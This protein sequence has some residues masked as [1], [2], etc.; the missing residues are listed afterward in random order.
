MRYLALAVDYDG[1]AASEDHLSDAATR[2]LER[3]PASGRRA[4]LLTGRRLVELFALCPQ[5]RLFDLV[6]AEN[7]AV[8]YDPRRREETLLATPPP[9]RFIQQLRARG[10]EPLEVGKVVVVAHERHRIII[11]E[12]IRELGLELQVI[13]NRSSVM[14]LP[15]GV[16]K[17]SG[18]AV[19]LRRLGLSRH[20]A[21]GIGDAENDYSFIRYCECGAA[22]ANAVDSLKE[23]ADLVTQSPN[24]RGVAELVDE[25]IKNDL[26]R[27]EGK[28]DRH[29]VMIGTREDG[30]A[31]RIP[32]YGHNILIA[33]PSGCGKS[34]GTA[35][36]VERLIDKTYQV[37]IIDP[38][39]DYSALRPVIALGNHRRA[40]SANEVLSILEDP[41]LN[42][43]VN[44]LGLPLEDRPFFFAQLIP[45]LQAMRARN[46]RPHWII[47]DEAH[48]MLPQFWGHAESTMPRMLGETILVTVHPD[49]VSPAMLAAVDIVF[50]IGPSPEDTL[51]KFANAAGRQLSWPEGLAYRPRHAVAWFVSHGIPP[52]LMRPEPTRTE[53][54]RHH[55]KYAEGDLRY[56]SFYFR[57]PDGRHNLKAQNLAVFCQIAAGIDEATW[58]YHL[59]K[60]D[61][62]RWIREAVRDPWLADHIEPIE[63]RPDLSPQ[64]TR[65]LVRGLICARYTLPE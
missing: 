50:A 43:S 62:S 4:V 16:N 13:Y 32:P 14:V 23:S 55:R 58:M 51:R 37:C 24:G 7:G 41:V 19:A 60:N 57:G 39:G 5:L 49:H 38:E 56:H 15:P 12:T 8:L 59:R 26:K 53:R 2:A 64:Q 45:S 40:P 35:G 30:S 48:H 46:G 33:G 27:L 63:R 17:A 44:L 34:T 28:I 6:V 65:D 31:V 18:L 36:I 9:E 22:V 1:T 29:L 52:F 61:Y 25:L 47:L 21:I 42:L 54:I 11:H 3:L 10:V 20:E